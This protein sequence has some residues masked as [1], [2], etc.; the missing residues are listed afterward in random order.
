MRSIFVV[1]VGRSGTTLLANLLGSHPLLVPVYETPFLRNLLLLCD[2]AGWYWGDSWSRRV[3]GVLVPGAVPWWFRQRCVKYKKKCEQYRRII[4]SLPD[5]EELQKL[6]IRQ[7]YENFPYKDPC[8]FFDLDVMVQKTGEFLRDLESGPVGMDIYALARNYI[9][10]LFRMHCEKATKPLWVNKTPRLLLCMEQ[11][12]KLYPG[13]QCIHIVRD[14]RDVTASNLSLAWGPKDVRSAARRWKRRLASR[15]RF[16]PEQLHYLEVRYEDLIRSPSEVLHNLFSFLDVDVA[17]IA[18][19]LSSF[20]LYDQKI[21]AWRS[22]FSR[23][24]REIFAQECGELLIELGY[25]QDGS[26]VNE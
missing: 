10:G 8:I 15:K 25:E 17:P 16:D 7:K 11:L 22:V 20:H 19:I 6:N 1:G 13:A 2:R 21:G 26:W 23:K 24:D 3:W 5:F 14:G 12:Q 4:R 9:D 18:M